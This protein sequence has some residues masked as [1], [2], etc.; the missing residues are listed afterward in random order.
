MNTERNGNETGDTHLLN[1]S[2]D[3]MRTTALGRVT[4]ST[5]VSL[6]LGEELRAK[7]VVA[8]PDDVQHDEDE[9]NDGQ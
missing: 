5:D 7:R 8:L 9:G 3:C 1:G 6:I 2:D 4:E